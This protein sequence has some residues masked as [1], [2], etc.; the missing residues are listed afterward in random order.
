VTTVSA[1]TKEGCAPA[2]DGRLLPI[3]GSQPRLLRPDMPDLVNVLASRL[4]VDACQDPARAG[5]IAAAV[6]ALTELAE[7]EDDPA[8][9]E[10]QDGN[11]GL[12]RPGSNLLLLFL[13]GGDD[14]E[15][16]IDDAY[17]WALEISLLPSTSVVFPQA[18]MPLDSGGFEDGWEPTVVEYFVD[19]FGGV[20]FDSSFQPWAP[21]VTDGFVSI[22]TQW[23][24]SGWP[25]D[26]D[27]DGWITWEAGEIRVFVDGVE[28]PPT[29]G[30]GEPIWE[31]RHS[32][33]AVRFLPGHLPPPGSKLTLTYLQPC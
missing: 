24:L 18:W 4:A 3:D 7:L 16:T 30:D 15:A 33:R 8:H 17:R 32:L 19:S 9:P 28:L 29:D 27:D 14:V 25:Y 13:L 11:A 23:R 26:A 12:L 6:R 2:P 5:A 22:P 31:Y 1:S 21:P 20:L 10:P